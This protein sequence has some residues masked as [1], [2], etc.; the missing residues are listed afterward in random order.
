MSRASLAMHYLSFSLLASHFS[1]SVL[2]FL[3]LLYPSRSSSI[4]SNH[5]HSNLYTRYQNT[6]TFNTTYPPHHE[7]TYSPLRGL[8]RQRQRQHHLQ[9]RP[10]LLRQHQTALYRLPSRPRLPAGWNVGDIYDQLYIGRCNAKQNLRADANPPTR[11]SIRNQNA[12]ARQGYRDARIFRRRRQS[13]ILPM[14]NVGLQTTIRCAILTAR[15]TKARAVRRM[16]GVELAIC[17]VERDVF[18]AA[19]LARQR[20]RSSCRLRHR[21]L[22]DPMGDVARTLE[23]RLVTRKVPMVDAVARMA[24][25][26][27]PTDSMLPP[28]LPIKRILLT[29][30]AVSLPMAA[31]AAARLPQ[32]PAHRQPCR[33]RSP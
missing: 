32:L 30:I 3:L 27:Q 24:T 28:F 23:E 20:P 14:G 29:R 19:R 18:R 33:L 31:K 7:D 13:S 16:G 15:C 22:L 4:A 1:D 9:P 17:T 26:A 5:H 12:G 21:Q 6:I 2:F 8:G 11:I 10:A 25:V